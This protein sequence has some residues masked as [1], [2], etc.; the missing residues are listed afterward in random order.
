MS[1]RPTG[2]ATSGRALLDLPEID[3]ALCEGTLFWSQARELVRIAVPETEAEWLEWARGRSAR[4]ITAQMSI[5]RKGERP[6][7]PARRRIRNA[8][9]RPDGRMNA[10]QWEKWNAA[11]AKLEAELDRPVT[12][13]EMMEQMA[14]LLLSTRADGSVPGR[15]PVNDAHYTIVTVHDAAS[16]AMAWLGSVFGQRVVPVGVDEFGESGTLR[17]LYGRF[18]FLPGQIVNA[19]LL[20]LIQNGDI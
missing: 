9:F 14:D 2:P 1:P 18:G 13:T 10:L 7:D 19:A 15:M 16:H 8:S 4:E 17:E 3:R 11:R 12:D 5:R 20:A 6:T